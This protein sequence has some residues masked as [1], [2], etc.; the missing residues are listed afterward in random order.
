MTEKLTAC[1]QTL[2]HEKSDIFNSWT[3]DL[4]P[5]TRKNRSYTYSD[6]KLHA[7][8][9]KPKRERETITGNKQGSKGK[10]KYKQLYYFA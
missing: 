3:R 1:S 5:L 2:N 7:T 6:G 8:K 4:T 10:Y 9:N